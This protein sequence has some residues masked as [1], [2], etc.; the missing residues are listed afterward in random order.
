MEG[1]IGEKDD[2]DAENSWIS[3]GLP[4]RVPGPTIRNYADISNNLVQRDTKVSA[5]DVKEKA[6]FERL[7]SVPG[8][9]KIAP[10]VT[11]PSARTSPPLALRLFL[12][13]CAIVS[14]SGPS[15]FLSARFAK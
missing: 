11:L 14:P 13:F 5:I 9:R 15:I 12:D 10:F 6:F 2:C 3:E 7:Y 1:V 8:L 4:R